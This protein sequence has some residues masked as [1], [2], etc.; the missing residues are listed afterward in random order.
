MK[1]VN[2]KLLDRYDYG[3]NVPLRGLEI[4]GRPALTGIDPEQIGDYVI[5]TVRDPLCAYDDDPAAQIAELLDNSHLVA[6]TG[7][8]TTY[9]GHYQGAHISVV[10]GGS[11][12]PEAELILFE[13]LER[14]NASTYIRVGGSRGM[15]EAVRPGDIVIA[16]G[17]VR[18]EGMTQAYISPSYPAACSYEVVMALTQAAIE[19]K[20]RFHVGITRSTDSDFVAGG[21]PSVGGYLQPQHID[22]VDYYA[23]AGVLNG[24]RESAAIVTLA[25]LFG[26]RGGSICSDADNIVT[27]EK[28][29]AGSGH[30]HAIQVALRGLAI[31]HQ[32]D[33]EARH[34]GQIF[35][36]PSLRKR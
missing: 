18:D 5:I 23:R 24:D 16:R 33:E 31:L 20:V 30:N 14:T 3:R 27:G 29:E 12:S 2:Q 9:S 32:L 11:G 19:A 22:V 26:K 15:N 6:R 10:S 17:V 21:R 1:K 25:T 28:F 35:W 4:N 7:M 8:F 34:A 13:F 36:T